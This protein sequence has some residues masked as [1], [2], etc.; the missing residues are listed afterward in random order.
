M[1]KPVRGFLDLAFNQHQPVKAFELYCGTPYV[2]HNTHAPADGPA[3]ARYLESFVS[4]FPEL[5]ID[6]KR[7]LVDGEFVATHSLLKLRN[8]DRGAV[9]MDIFRV[10]EGR[11]VEHWDAVADIPENPTNPPF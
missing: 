4:Q 6:V 1:D 11:I 3:S 7:I 9:A 2:Q 5:S 8:A 10:R